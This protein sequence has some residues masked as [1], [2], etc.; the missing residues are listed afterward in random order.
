[1]Q[2]MSGNRDTESDADTSGGSGSGGSGSGS[3]GHQIVENGTGGSAGKSKASKVKY[4]EE[5]IDGKAVKARM[6]RVKRVKNQRLGVEMESHK[7]T[8]TWVKA[9]TIMP[10]SAFDRAGV[11]AG[12]VFIAVNGHSVVNRNHSRVVE[13][14]KKSPDVFNVIVTNA[15]NVPSGNST[16]TT[17]DTTPATKPS[18]R[19]NTPNTTATS[20][21]SPP[22]PKPAH[23]PRKGELVRTASNELGMV[24]YTDR[25][26]NTCVQIVEPDGSAHQ[27]GLKVGDTFLEIDGLNVAELGHQQIVA[28]LNEAGS[29]IPFVV[30]KT[31]VAG[32]VATQQPPVFPKDMK[33]E[34]FTVKR[35]ADNQLGI[36]LQSKKLQRGV[37]LTLVEATGPFGAA[38]VQEGYV[39][40]EIDG[41]N[42]LDLSHADVLDAL[43][44]AGSTI[45]VALVAAENIDSMPLPTSAPATPVAMD[46]EEE[47]TTNQ[48]LKLR[49][50]Q[51]E[52]IPAKGLG[53]ELLSMKNKK[54]I[55]VRAKTIDIAGPMAFAGVR[56][57][58]VFVQINGTPVL[59]AA[60]QDVIN[61]FRKAGQKFTVV[62]L[63]SSELDA[64]LQSSS[65]NAA[66]AQSRP[67][68][69]KPAAVPRS[70][71]PEQLAF[72]RETHMGKVDTTS[73]FT[74][75]ASSRIINTETEMRNWNQMDEMENSLGCINHKVQQRS[76]FSKWC[77][78]LFYFDLLGAGG[79]THVSHAV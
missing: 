54:Q 45:R 33:L 18:S 37:R 47:V 60:H 65:K 32:D 35:G 15:E 63:A 31:D 2:G 30:Q 74:D 16:A 25:S 64:Q 52:R 58:D 23:P 77:Q 6:C 56:V 40:V 5:V 29:T 12:D 38:G 4:V 41:L 73:Q 9:R 76:P 62:V 53:I 21:P 71:T 46:G 78:F 59:N 50:C 14:V 67:T 3:G 79:N 7:K 72:N 20:T 44:L 28:I 36:A 27:A 66:G 49:K 19:G 8:P 17:T 10:G 61:T 57:G 68:L 1:M 51:V 70:I 24:L 26:S 34:W 39:F 11:K 43:K 22:K 42:V 48:G 13:L 55:G 75:L 69:R